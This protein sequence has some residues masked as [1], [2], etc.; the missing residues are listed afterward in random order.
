MVIGEDTNNYLTFDTTDGNEKLIT[1]GSISGIDG[2]TL[3]SSAR[4]GDIN[5]TGNV[6]SNA[7]ATDIDF[8]GDN[9][10]NIGTIGTI[11]L[12]LN[13]GDITNVDGIVLNTLSVNGSTMAFNLTSGQSIALVIGTTG[14]EYLTFD[15]DNQKL[16]I[17]KAVELDGSAISGSNCIIT[18]NVISNAV[19][20]ASTGI[21]FNANNLTN[22]GTI[23]AT[24]F[25]LNNNDVTNVGDTSL[26]S[27]T[28]DG[29]DI[30]ININSGSFKVNTDTLVVNNS[31]GVSIAGDLDVVGAV[32]ING[33]TGT[34][35][36]IIT[37]VNGVLLLWF[38]FMIRQT[39]K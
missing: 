38:L 33:D 8:S 22:I 6:I 30:N 12:D 13:S 11:A 9:L 29:A 2:I 24:G 15:T 27:I 20:G 1:G 26:N 5:I 17:N 16:I 28:A 36:K 34:V 10:T 21:N 31:T 37:S 4:I 32:T 14:N 25:N 18:G 23:S 39:L 3:I 19:S 35:L 7:I